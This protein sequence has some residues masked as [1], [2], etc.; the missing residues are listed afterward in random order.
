M[1][2]MKYHEHPVCSVVFSPDGSRLASASSERI[3]VWDVSSSKLSWTWKLTK[4]QHFERFLA[5][6]ISLDEWKVVACSRNMYLYLGHP[7]W[8]THFTIT[9]VN[10][11]ILDGAH[12]TGSRLSCCSDKA[13]AGICMGHSIW[14]TC[15]SD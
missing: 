11:C 5:V 13:W 10:R 6:A 8:K 3:C 9:Q 7:V 1:S 4:E 15:T 12:S 14:Y 2:E